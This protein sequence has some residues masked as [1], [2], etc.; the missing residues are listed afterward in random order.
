[1]T[2]RQSFILLTA[3]AALSWGCENPGPDETPAPPSAKPT[4]ET[5]VFTDA[6]A[7]YFG[8]DGNTGISDMWYIRLYTAMEQD[9]S[10]NPVGPGQ[11]MQISC[12]TPQDSGLTTDCLE[13]VYSEPSGIDDFSSGTFNPGYMI[14]VDLPD[15]KIEAPVM[16][17]FGDIFAGRTDFVPDLLK[18][19]YVIID[20]N[21]DGTY[22][23]EGTLTGHMLQKRNFTYTGILEL[24]Q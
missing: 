10:G 5:I 20:I 16:S 21:N 3:G 12:N 24:T 4:V 22:T 18:D 6:Q 14:S 2:L 19:G 23:I 15:G 11:L 1:M 13:G 9:V 8:D 7:I 17:Y